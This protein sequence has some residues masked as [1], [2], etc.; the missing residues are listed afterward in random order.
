MT[1]AWRLANN[2]AVFGS[3]F[4][5]LGN[6]HLTLVA[7]LTL[8]DC[9][10]AFGLFLLADDDLVRNLLEFALADLVAELLTPSASAAAPR[11]CQNASILS[12]HS[13]CT[14]FV[15]FVNF[16]KNVGSKEPTFA[17]SF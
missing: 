7:F 16:K 17:N 15:G 6:G 2:L 1:R 4:E 11:S 9:D 8:V 3:H 10:N 12:R 14:L 5:E 13:A